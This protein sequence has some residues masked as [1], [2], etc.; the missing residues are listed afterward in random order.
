M[1]QD[2]YTRPDSTTQTATAY[3]ANID[4]ACEVNERGAG[5]QFQ[6]H[7][8][9]TPDMTVRVEAGVI[10]DHS[11]STITSVAAQSTSTITAPST[12]PRMD[13]VSIHQSTGV[14]TVTTGTE[15]ST[16]VAPSLPTANFPIAYVTLQTTTTTIT[17]ELIT[18][19]RVPFTIGGGSSGLTELLDDTTP[20]LY[21]SLDMN[22]NGLNDSNGN[23]LMEFSET[24]GAVNHIKVTNGATGTNPILEA[25]GGDANIYLHIRAK[26]SG[27]VALGTAALKFPN[28]DGSANQV[29]KTNGSGTLSFGTFSGLSA[30]AY[31][32]FTTGS[33]PTINSSSNVSSVVKSGNDYIVT[34]TSAVSSANYLAITGGSSYYNAGITAKS[35]SSCTVQ[36]FAPTSTSPQGGSGIIIS[37]LIIGA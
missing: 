18:D 28:S 21:A 10:Y 31:V 30:D 15:T 34:F 14:L 29:L 17:D 33:S 11:N 35:T 37:L 20:Q 16:P 24:A 5:I 36:V 23:E 12:K 8:Q 1:T 6:A 3:K 9:T 27:N 25:T 22:G 19:A 32:N 26:G 7:E 2:K 4:N 13:L